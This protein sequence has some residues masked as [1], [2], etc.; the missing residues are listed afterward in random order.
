MAK[1]ETSKKGKL[2]PAATRGSERKA[3]QPTD[4]AALGG[5]KQEAPANIPPSKPPQ[6]LG[7]RRQLLQLR[8]GQ[9]VLAMLRL[10]RY[11][12]LNIADLKAC[13]L[14]PLLQDR[15]AFATGEDDNGAA[16][17][18]G[19]AVWASVSDDVHAKIAGAANRG[20]FPVRLDKGEWRS[21]DIVWLLDILAPD[22]KAATTVFMNFHKLASGRP[23]RMHPAVAQSVD[24]AIID[25]IR[26]LGQSGTKPNLNS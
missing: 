11:R 19:M 23:F 1:L 17:P 25:K 6:R 22:R 12:H 10:A 7:A 20:Q 3:V 13:A 16:T 18:V 8:M 4:G 15:I 2:A 26:E 5:R 9:V 21:G 14:E 24:P